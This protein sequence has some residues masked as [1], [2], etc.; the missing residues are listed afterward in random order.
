[1]DAYYGGFRYPVLLIEMV[2]L[3]LYLLIS[4]A[5]IIKSILKNNGI[6]KDSIYLLLKYFGGLLALLI[7]FFILAIIFNNS[8]AQG[9]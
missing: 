9:D 6:R 2:V 8:S 1:M 4:L 3:P 7:I 5:H